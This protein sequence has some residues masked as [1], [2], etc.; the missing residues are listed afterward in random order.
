M[1]RKT[2]FSWKQVIQNGLIAGTIS[3]LVSLIGMV[4]AFAQRDIIFGAITMGQIFFLAP[5]FVFGYLTAK[6]AG[7]QPK[8][9]L[10][11]FGLLTGLSGA[12]LM[13]VFVL[14]GQAVNLRAVLINASPA[15]YRILLFGQDLPAGV[16]APLLIGTITGGTGAAIYLLP[17]RLRSGINQ[18]LIWVLLIGLLRDLL[19]IM[20]D[21]WGGLA[22]LFRWLF[23]QR[24]MSPEGAVT[25][26]V[27]ITALTYLRTTYKI[28]DVVPVKVKVQP[29]ISRGISFAVLVM[30]LL[31]LPGV[32]GRYPTE[33]LDNVGIFIIMGLGLNIVVGFA[34]ILD[35]GYVAFFAIGSYAMG[36]LTSPELGFFNMTYWQ[37]LPIVLVVSALSGAILGMPVLRMRGDYLAIVT[38]G[39]GEI[40]RLLVLSDWLRPFLGGS[41][42]IQRIARPHVG[43][44]VLATQ[45]Q[46]YY[47][48][49]AGCFITAFIAWRLKDSR[50]GRAWIA[51]REDEDVAQAMGINKVQIKL[52]AFT[53]GATLAGLSGT[54]F[55]AKLTSV[56]PHSFNLLISI[57]TLSLI[58]VGGMGSIPGV[59]V[60][61]LA[62]YGLPELLREFNE[63]RLLAYGAV[64]VAMMILRPEGLWPEARR[65]LELHEEEQEVVEE[66]VKGLEVEGGKAIAPATSPASVYTPANPMNPTDKG[67]TANLEN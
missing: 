15:L 48:I 7:N 16:W 23:A 21:Q 40:I 4:A 32:I 20:I 13:V 19:I 37:A 11:L 3:I 14:I 27:F 58:I 24:G 34:G 1:A 29:Q 61:A 62:L 43:G 17:E 64:L 35:L 6:Q 5:I 47:L 67:D 56:Y 26:F 59:I 8:I 28:S 66:V 18:G 65:K 44:M 42:G 30:L 22:P 39:F 41:T 45:E 49:L 31:I 54:I 36:V 51:M 55:A 60:G 12:A 25:L 10:A 53:V 50:L 57:N 38:L 33:V 46:L 2:I 9:R 63:F 52:L